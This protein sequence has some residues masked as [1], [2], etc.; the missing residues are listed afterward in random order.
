MPRK[1]AR[2]P[3]NVFLNNRHVG[4]LTWQSSGAIDFVYN[5]SWLEWEHVNVCLCRTGR[6]KPPVGL[7]AKS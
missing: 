7:R 5:P 4:R 3:L 1:P 2:A 6:H